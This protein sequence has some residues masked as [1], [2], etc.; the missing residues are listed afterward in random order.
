MEFEFSED[1]QRFHAEVEAFLDDHEDPAV[2]DPTRE[3]MA[4]I[5]DTPERRAFMAK[6]GEKGWLGMTWPKEY[7]GRD[8]TL[9]EQAIFLEEYDRAG[10]PGGSVNAAAGPASPLGARRM[11]L[12]GR[13]WSPAPSYC[14]RRA[15]GPMGVA[16]S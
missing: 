6:V 1:Q 14:M 12:F 3:N 7:G 16:S 2:M 8:A 10:A 5:C 9:T 13:G 4:Q 15:A 11:K